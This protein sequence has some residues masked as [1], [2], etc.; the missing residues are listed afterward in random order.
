[1][2]PT[3]LSAALPDPVLV[4]REA[5]FSGPPHKGDLEARARYLSSTYPVSF[6]EARASLYRQEEVLTMNMNTEEIIFWFQD[7]LFCQM[8]LLYLLS[9]FTSV[10]SKLVIVTAP[11]GGFVGASANSMK[12]V[13]EGRHTLVADEL[14]LGETVFHAFSASSPEAIN[15]IIISEDTLFPH[16]ATL[17]AQ[18]GRFPLVTDGLTVPQ[19]ILLE[20]IAAGAGT[21]PELFQYF[22][23][24]DQLNYGPGDWQVW[25]ML[26]ELRGA[27]AMHKEASV[28]ETE[29]NTREGTQTHQFQITPLGEKILAGKADLIKQFGA[30][31]WIGGVHI[32]GNGPQWRR[33]ASGTLKY[34]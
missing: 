14:E 18:V 10:L 1:M 24:H 22:Q 3:W 21:F 6:R 19:R 7:D 16:S 33:T 5:L 17:R 15:D 2:H 11:P 4:W 28:P 9:R 32:S 23:A 29:N 20:G 25:E 26:R 13:F 12:E 34:I 8:N 31:R 30:E 27:I